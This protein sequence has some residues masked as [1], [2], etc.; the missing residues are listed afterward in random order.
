M[1]PKSKEK[2]IQPIDASMDDVA[3]KIVKDGAMSLLPVPNEKTRTEKR[4]ELPIAIGKGSFKEDFGIDIDCYVLN[5]NPKTAVIS[6]T[7]M[8]KAIGLSRGGNRLVRFI[9][10]KIMSDY[11][12]PELR[13]KVDNPLI[14]QS[15]KSRPKFDNPKEFYGYDVTN[16]IDLCKAIIAANSDGRLAGQRYEK[17]IA[18]AHII[19]S[20]SAKLG[21]KNLVYALAG[22]RPEVEEVIA[23]FKHYVLEEAKKYESEFP[24]ELYIEWQRLYNIKPP[25]RGKNWKNMHLTVD[26]IYEPLAQS[27]GKLLK[28]L[29]GAKEKKGNRNTKL[30]QFL[31]EVGAK[32]LRIHLGRV[33]EMAQSSPDRQIYEAKIAERFGRQFQFSL[34]PNYPIS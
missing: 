19:L 25:Q 23:A 3:Q 27:D 9:D 34:I 17:M 4:D 10:N 24:T 7:G 8:E 26:H 31:N 12:A 16:L 29:R 15:Y 6:Q 18:Q 33:L 5:D 13:Q 30:F 14:F 2:I 20:A 22:Y 1:P 28:L 11:I 21:I 32:A